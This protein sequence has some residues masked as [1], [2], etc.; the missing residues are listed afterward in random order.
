MFKENPLSI[1]GILSYAGLLPDLGRYPF[2][3]FGDV[4]MRD[5]FLEELE[6][7]VLLNINADKIDNTTP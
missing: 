3:H 4:V 6:K 1:S 5:W 7:I 2:G